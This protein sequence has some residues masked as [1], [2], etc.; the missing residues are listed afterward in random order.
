MAQLVKNQ[1]SVWETL[2][3]SLGKITWRNERQPTPVFCLEN[4][5][6]SIVHGVAKSQSDFHFLSRPLSAI[7]SHVVFQANGKLTL[8]NLEWGQLIKTDVRSKIVQT[9]NYLGKTLP[10]W[11]SPC[12]MP[13]ILNMEHCSDQVFLQWSLHSRHMHFPALWLSFL[14]SIHASKYIEITFID[15][16][17][18]GETR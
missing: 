6:D 14:A 9:R 13:V 17:D 12:Y 3:L 15:V 10:T 1:P 2:V 5:I 16:K 4:S 8:R 11:G 7:G 18:Y